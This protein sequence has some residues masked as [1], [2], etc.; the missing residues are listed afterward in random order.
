MSEIHIV[1]EYDR[2]PRVVW[3]ALTDPALVPLWTSTGRGGTPEG[4]S[5]EVGNRFRFVGKPVPGWDGIVRCEVL[6]VAAPR[7]LRYSWQGGEKE[8]PSFVAYTLEPTATGTRFTYDHTRFRGVGGFILSKI[9]LGPVRRKMLR[10]GLPTALAELDDNG[11][12][13]SGSALRRTSEPNG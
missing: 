10:T 4:F 9:V 6:E 7:L 1:N 5:P 8:A 12:L 2:P 13:R 3:T 11:E